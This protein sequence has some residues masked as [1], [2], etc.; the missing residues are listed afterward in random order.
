[1]EWI[2]WVGPVVTA[3]L[4]IGAVGV[5]VL[6]AGRVLKESADVLSAASKAVEDKVVTTD[7]IMLIKKEVDDVKDALSAFTKGGGQQ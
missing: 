6:K 2:G 4:S 7:E 1:M 5:V 3:A